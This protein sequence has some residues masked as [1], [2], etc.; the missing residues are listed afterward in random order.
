MMSDWNGNPRVVVITG[1]S[2]GVGRATVR[3]FARRGDHIGLLARG[4]DGTP[5]KVWIRVESPSGPS[6]CGEK[7]GKP[8]VSPLIWAIMP[9]IRT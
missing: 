7:M 5:F 6:S 4:C 1:A 8:D 2:A 9:E 3:A